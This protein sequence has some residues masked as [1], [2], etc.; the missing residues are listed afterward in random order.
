MKAFA[1]SLLLGAASVAFAQEQQVLTSPDAISNVADKVSASMSPKDWAKKADQAKQA[2]SSLTNEA[3]QLWDEVAMMFPEAM[4]KASFF[5]APKPSVR[6]HDSEWDHHVSGA[7]IQ[8]LWVEN[9]DGDKE[10]AIS[11]KLENYNMRVKKVDPAALGVDK[12]KQY[13]GYLDD[14]EEDKH[15]FYCKHQHSMVRM[16]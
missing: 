15:L 2:L 13:S 14:E 3:H 12:V 16:R 4:N 8:S 11:G 7:D 5:S 9:A 10:R 6:R 1:T